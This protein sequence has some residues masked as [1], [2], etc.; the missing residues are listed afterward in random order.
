[1]TRAPVMVQV[2]ARLRRLREER[3]WSVQV[4]ADY[5]LVSKSSLM[6]WELGNRSPAVDVLAGMARAYGVTLASLM[7]DYGP[8]PMLGP[9]G[10]R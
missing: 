8:S 9:D 2:G 6:S 10:D 4:A 7:P 5:A 1:M 3:G